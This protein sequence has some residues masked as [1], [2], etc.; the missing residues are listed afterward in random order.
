MIGLIDLRTLDKRDIHSN[1]AGKKIQE[2]NITLMNEASVG[3]ASSQAIP[4]SSRMI[5]MPLRASITTDCKYERPH[6][7]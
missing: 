1:S 3:L 2:R 4:R 6:V 7:R 5:E